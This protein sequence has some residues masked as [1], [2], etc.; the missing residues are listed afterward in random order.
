MN[1]SELCIRRPAMVVALALSLVAAGVL[2]YLKIPVAALPS[3]NTPVINVN[4]DLPGAS[5]ETMASSVALP[6]EKQFA[7]IGGLNVITSTSTTGTTS[8]TL[9]FDS[10]MDINVAALE[11]QAALLRAQRQLPPEVTELPSYRKTNPADSPTLFMALNSP[12][13]SLSELNDYAENLIAPSLA[14]IPGVA[15]VSVNGQK[16]FAVRVRANLEQLNAR[17]MTLDELGAAVRAANSHSPLGIIEGPE[18][19]LTIQADAG[20]MKAAQFAEL[21]VGTRNG[22]AVRLKDVAS[23]DDS[24]LSVRSGASYNGDNSILLQLQ[25]Q[26]DANT[27]RLVDAVRKLMPRL[28]AQ[29]PASVALTLTFDSSI[30][31]RE[32]IHD[33]NLTLALTVALVV[34]VIFLFLRRAAATLIPV[35]TL[36]V[37]LLGALLLLYWLGYSLDNVSLLGITLAVGLV[38]DDAIVV[39]ENIVRHVEKGEPPLKAALVGAREMGFTIVSISLSLVA[40]FIPIFFMPG[41][42]GLLFHEFAVVVSLA[43]LV[44]ALVSLTLVPL[45]ASRLLPPHGQEGRE[46]W[47]GLRFERG[48][49]DLSRA[50]AATL[51]WSLAHRAVILL[52]ALGTFVLTVVLYQ[53]IPKGF[54]PEEDLGRIRVTTEA[55]EDVSAPAMAALQTRLAAAFQ[56]N[57]NIQAVVSITGGGSSAASGR[58]ILALKPQGE[59]GKLAAVMDSLRKTAKSVPGMNVYMSPM[60]NLQLGGRSSKSRYQYTLQSVS[61]GALDNWAEKVGDAMRADPLF[62]DVTSDS[63]NKGLQATLKID[64]DKAGLLGVQMADVRSALYLAFGDRQVSTI[65]APSASYA[66]ILEAADRGFEDALA[67]VSVRGKSGALVQLSSFASVERSAGPTSISHQGQLQAITLSFNLAPGAALGAATA[68]IEQIGRELQL[69]ASIITKY[70][71]EAAVFQDAQSSQLLLIGIALLV[72]YVL[73][74]V[75]YESYIHP[76]TILAGL[77]SAAVGALLTL[78]LFDMDLTLIAIIG[79]LMLIGIVKKNAIMMIDFALDAQR[80]QGLSPAEAIREACVLRFRPI[81]MTTLAALMGALPLAFGLGAGAELRQPLGLAVVGGLLFSQVVTLYIT[82]VIYLYLDRFAGTGPMSDQALAAAMAPL[83]LVPGG[84][85]AHGAQGEERPALVQVARH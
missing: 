84:H 56:A 47:I 40:V 34:L 7:T 82:P 39:L 16:R 4:A 85:E 46:T 72:I 51:D 6:L 73:L 68:R 62:R 43:I 19:T 60:Q 74:V 1:L 59:R 53:G 41:V 44:S 22:L 65:Y 71:G 64:A 12:S 30:P 33:V 13:L 48:F 66:V 2:A 5:P 8:L 52:L 35:I 21:I 81:M 9:E 75:L 23:V 20:L 57:P 79:I 11:V 38:V 31:I 37:S 50:Y 29:L 77:P 54:F 17:N 76:I 78:R 3:Y 83:T 25:R 28:Q 27:V 10:S 14:T 18:Q 55:S 61:P 58:M 36:P 49:A 80:G 42:I 24:F 32:A 67:K 26:P 69:P 15:Q 45:M 70:G 63:Q